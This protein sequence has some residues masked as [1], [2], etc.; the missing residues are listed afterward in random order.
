LSLAASIEAF[1]APLML[2]GPSAGAALEPKMT[3]DDEPRVPNPSFENPDLAERHSTAMSDLSNKS[4]ED[5]FRLIDKVARSTRVP[6][7]DESVRGSAEE[8]NSYRGTG[9]PALGQ[10]IFLRWS[11][12]LHALVCGS[13]SDDKSLRAEIIAALVSKGGGAAAIIAGSL[14]AA[15]GISQTLAAL[16]SVVLL[17][18]IVAPVQ[19]ELCATWSTYN[20]SY[21]SSSQN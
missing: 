5:L 16:I 17:R 12:A 1:Y 11:V 6:I 21:K 13:E 3:S 7:G 19:E 18:V 9:D 15:F 8:L 10:R 4:N 2:A 14:V 20:S